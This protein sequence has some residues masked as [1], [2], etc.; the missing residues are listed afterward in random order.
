MK[1]HYDILFFDRILPRYSGNIQSKK[2]A[3]VWARCLKGCLDWDSF[4]TFLRLL[5]DADAQVRKR[6]DSF[7]STQVIQLCRVR[8]VGY[9]THS[10]LLEAW[11]RTVPRR[12]VVQWPAPSYQEILFSYCWRN[13]GSY[14]ACVLLIVYGHYLFISLYFWLIELRIDLILVSFM[15]YT[16]FMSISLKVNLISR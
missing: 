5:S 15:N 12:D 16:I 4:A 1:N 2:T 9:G 13:G 7:A 14:I 11:L 8:R 10:R 6:R 3:T